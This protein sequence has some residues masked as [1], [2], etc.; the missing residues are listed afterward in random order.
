M[1]STD[2]PDTAD[3]Y[4][5]SKK[6]LP[7]AKRSLTD[8]ATDATDGKRNSDSS[9]DN[10]VSTQNFAD[11]KN[12]LTFQVHDSSVSTDSK[13]PLLSSRGVTVADVL[14]I[15]PGARVISKTAPAEKPQ[16]QQLKLIQGGKR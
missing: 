12:S 10:T 9:A 8:G 11:I 6:N 3:M 2:G 7:T 13:I 1:E 5:K 16:Q 15:F 4:L 14:R